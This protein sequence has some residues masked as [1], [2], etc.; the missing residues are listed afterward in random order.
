VKN[1]ASDLSVANRVM[2]IVPN[3]GYCVI[4]ANCV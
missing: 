4:L 1:L 3:S 2:K